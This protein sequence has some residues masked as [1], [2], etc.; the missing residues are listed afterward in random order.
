MVSK[1]K[2]AFL[3]E[4]N[5]VIL[6]STSGILETSGK[7]RA[8]LALQFKINGENQVAKTSW[9]V[10]VNYLN[11]L[12]SGNEIAIKYDQANPKTIYPNLSWAKKI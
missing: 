10:D 3:I 8:E 11:L 1:N 9:L 2:Y 6:S 4:A 5:A 7:A 12:Q